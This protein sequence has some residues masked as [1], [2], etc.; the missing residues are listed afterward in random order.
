MAV[1]DG[2]PGDSFEIE[3]AVVDKLGA[4]QNLA[5]A[6][7]TAGAVETGGTDV[8]VDVLTVTDE[9]G[10]LVVGKFLENVLGIGTWTFYC[11]VKIS[12]DQ[13]VVVT[14]TISVTDLVPEVV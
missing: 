5:G 3:V 14:E 4:P 7:I 11:R 9:P 13:K 1:I 6:T 8:P 2:K 12:T 10:G